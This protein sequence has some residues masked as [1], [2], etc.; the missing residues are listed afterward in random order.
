M[1]YIIVTGGVMSG[2]G[3]GITAA[4]TCRLLQSLGFK[5][6]AIK[7]D[8]YLN[9][10]AGTISP[11]EHGEV[12]VTEDGGEIDLDMGHYERFLDVNLT[13]NHNITTGQIYGEVIEKERAGDYLGRT[14]QIIPHVTDVIKDRI[15]KVARESEVEACL[16]EIGGTVGDIESMPFLEAARQLRLEEGDKNVMF[17][18]V[19]L[20]PALS[21]VGEQKTKPTQ[22]SVKELRGLGITPDAIVCRAEKPV[23]EDVKRKISLFCDVSERAV[24]SAHDV[25]NIY[26]IPLLLEK[27]GLSDIIV[28][29]LALKPRRKDLTDWRKIVEGMSGA[30][31]RVKIAMVGKYAKFADTYM[32][33]NEA[34]KHAGGVL[35]YAVD[36]DW[37]EAE[38]F[39]ED[40]EKLKLLSDYGGV[41]VPGGFG[42]RGAEG[43]IAAIN[44]A[45]VNKIPFLGLC[46]G[47]QLAAVEFARNVTGLSRANSTEVD[48]DTPHPVIDLLP[49]QREIEKKGGTM[50]LGFGDVILSTGTRAFEI[51]GV[52]C[53]RERHRHR[54]EVNPK[55]F[56]KLTGAG[57]VLSGRSPNGKIEILELHD[58]PYI[59]TQFHPEFKSRPGKP[60]P[61]FGWLVE[62]SLSKR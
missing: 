30:R 9:V 25:E 15:K 14:V 8:P 6:T 48:P 47:F 54:Y 28:Q 53:V 22:H 7:I 24:V 59:A 43:K 16:V 38:I 45:R 61:V 32:S 39:E 46:F 17:V 23:G 29:K 40:P 13:K 41:L 2:L 36:I 60:S 5:V 12:F 56:K 34:L 1:K 37:I 10:D 11:F 3:K 55:Y 42:T 19:T 20:I 35:G 26:E 49:E 4:S 50:R 52:K 58:R 44:Y 57:L 21:V 51:Y 31:G 33:V 18:H 27:E 62:A